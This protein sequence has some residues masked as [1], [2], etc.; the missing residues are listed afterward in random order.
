MFDAMERWKAKLEELINGLAAHAD[1][2]E[3][4]FKRIK[5]IVQAPSSSALIGE[6]NKYVEAGT[7]KTI[8][9]VLSPT[10]GGILERR[11]VT[12]IPREVYDTTADRK[13][14]VDPTRDMEIVYQGR[15][16]L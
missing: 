15:R 2:R 8:Y 10:T 3:L 7:I 4:E 1:V 11:S 12:D 13:F 14:V 16:A 9:R 6:L 5:S